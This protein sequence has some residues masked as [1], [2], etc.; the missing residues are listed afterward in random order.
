MRRILYD[1]YHLKNRPDADPTHY[2]PTWME[3]FIDFFLTIP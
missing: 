1:M 2:L 3:F